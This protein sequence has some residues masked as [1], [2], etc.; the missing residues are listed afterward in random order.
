MRANVEK[1]LSQ[2]TEDAPK[3]KARRRMLLTDGTADIIGLLRTSA[4]DAPIILEAT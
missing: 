4:V 2:V 1:V 3:V